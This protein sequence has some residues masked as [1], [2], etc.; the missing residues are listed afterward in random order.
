MNLKLELFNCLSEAKLHYA[1]DELMTD[2]IA[3]NLHPEAIVRKHH[4]IRL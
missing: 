1:V 2:H 3:H 4:G